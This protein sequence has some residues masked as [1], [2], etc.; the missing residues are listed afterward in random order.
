MAKVL[1]IQPK[2]HGR[3]TVRPLG[4]G[5]LASA[6]SAGGHVVSI[7]DNDLYG[8][9]SGDIRDSVALARPDIVGITTNILNQWEARDIGRAVSGVCSSVV[10]G[11]P[12]ATLDPASFLVSPVCQVIPGEAEETFVRFVDTGAYTPGGLQKNL[13]A[14]PFANMDLFE[15]QRYRWTLDGRAC[16]NMIASR[17]C[18][19]KCIYCYHQMNAVFRQRTVGNVL[20]EMRLLRDHYG[21]GAI[22]FFDDTF[23]M[24]RRWVEEFCRA[25]LTE[26]IGMVWQ[27]IA[28]SRTVDADLIRVMAEAGCRQISFGIESGSQKSLDL[29]GKNTTIE[30]N[31]KALLACK[32]AGVRT[33]AYLIIGLPWET[34]DDIAATRQFVAEVRPDYVQVFFATPFPNTDL[35]RLVEAGGYEIDREALVGARDFNIP[36]FETEHFSKSDLLG[37]R[38]EIMDIHRRYVQRITPGRL[39]QK[40]RA[41][42]RKW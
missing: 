9:T 7:F 28:V 8:H 11:G 40:L 15:W 34:A 12:Q 27:C 35:E 16:T 42:T 23:T 25:L 20:M 1:L 22:K 30:Q 41:S 31:R 38:L 17:G 32:R 21:F 36:L 3:S 29:M 39:W 13:D 4:L 24:R 5:Y 2:T 37:W 19:L 18:P 26:R 6:L 10:Y 14:I 33:K